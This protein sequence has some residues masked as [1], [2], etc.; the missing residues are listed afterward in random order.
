MRTNINNLIARLAAE[1]TAFMRTRF[2]APVAGEGGVCVRIAG[3]ICRLRVWPRAF[4][5]WGVFRPTSFTKA[6]LDREATM[7]ERRTY[8]KLFP[9][10]RLILTNAIAPL[11]TARPAQLADTRFVI[12]GDAL[13]YGVEDAEAFDTIVARFD[14]ERFWFD[15]I[16]PQADPAMGSYL[17]EAVVRMI[18][19]RLLTRAGLTPEQRMAYA[20]E[21]ADR[22]RR[23]VANERASGEYR[24]RLAVEHAG[25]ALR[26]FSELPDVYRVTYSVD[27]RRHTSVVRK[28]TLSVQ[29]AGVCLSGMD[30]QF[31]LASLVSVL[32]E[33]GRCGMLHGTHV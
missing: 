10:V 1:E 15:E 9:A 21:H 26:G 4:S 28:D 30:A 31:D 12:E 29:S 2:L 14:G 24:L 16:D 18:D 19:P 8:L 20:A 33:G 23:K 11:W 32:R 25:A 7:A 17:R 22:L 6:V 3:A 13:V 5:G 27:G